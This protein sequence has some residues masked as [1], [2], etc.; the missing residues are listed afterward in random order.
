MESV[1]DKIYFNIWGDLYNQIWTPRMWGDLYN[2][3]WNQV[4][5]EVR[6]QILMYIWS[7]KG[8]IN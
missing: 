2:Q 5:R 7:L 8:R 4:D 1:K 3:I 6:N